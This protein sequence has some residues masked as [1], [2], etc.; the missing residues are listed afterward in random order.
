MTL[1]MKTQCPERAKPSNGSPVDY[2]KPH[3][4]QTPNLCDVSGAE[5]TVGGGRWGPDTSSQTFWREQT[6][7]NFLS[8]ANKSQID[9]TFVLRAPKPQT[10][11][12]LGPG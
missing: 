2:S 7:L 6:L 1:D 9:E 11:K 8:S 10:I 12:V 5:R 3:W 4:K